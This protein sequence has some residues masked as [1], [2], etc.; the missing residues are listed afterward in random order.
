[1]AHVELSLTEAFDL[2]AGRVRSRH[3]H[4]RRQLRPVG[5]DR[6]RRR[7]ALP[8]HRRRITRSFRRPH[9]AAR[10]SASASR[11]RPPGCRCSTPGSAG[12]LHRGTERADR[13]GDREDPAAARADVGPAGP[14]PAAGAR[15]V[16]TA[17]RRSTPSPPRC[18]S[19]APS[20]APSR[21][22]PRSDSDGSDERGARRTTVGRRHG[23]PYPSLMLDLDLL[24]EEYAVCRLPAGSPLPP[25]LT[26]AG[27]NGQRRRLGD[28]GRRRGVDDLPRRPGAAGRDRG[29]AVALP[30]R[31]R[32]ARLRA[33]RHPGV[34]RRPACR[35]PGQHHGFSTYDTDYVLVPAVRLD[36]AIATLTKAGHRVAAVSGAKI[37]GVARRTIRRRNCLRRVV[38]AGRGRLRQATR[39][40]NDHP[41][42]RRRRSHRPRPR[43][44]PRAR[45]R[46]RPRRSRRPPRPR[47]LRPGSPKRRPSTAAAVR[48]A[49]RCSRSSGVPDW[50]PGRPAP[51]SSPARCARAPGSGP[52]CRCPTPTRCRSSP[53]ARP[54]R[55]ELVT[56]GTDVCSIPVRTGA[57]A[58]IR[59]A[60]C[61]AR[62]PAL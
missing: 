1:M 33:H 17:T 14:R 38:R 11:R 9:P 24:P 47:P 41:R 7:G 29:D 28:L 49:G 36:E 10:C 51:G 35:R 6:G 16:E 22:S 58:G 37:P 53:V 32:P 34:P 50:S 52:W 5:H 30:A 59:A 21:S 61:D 12:R 3:P 39:P 57:P 62:P 60:A 31:G 19:G 40:A 13:A 54:V 27:R 44:R 26:G 15:A 23:G 4:A 46:F 18:S 25:G 55:C 48:A 56:A 20:P 43:P 45:P 8:G 2:P 42:V